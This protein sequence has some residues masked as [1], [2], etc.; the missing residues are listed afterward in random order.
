MANGEISVKP[1]RR[2]TLLA[3]RVFTENDLLMEGLAC[4]SQVASQDR[5]ARLQT[6]GSAGRFLAEFDAA[7]PVLVA[8]V[9]EFA[10]V[11]ALMRTLSLFRW[12]RLGG[13][14]GVKGEIPLPPSAKRGLTP[15]TLASSFGGDWIATLTAPADWSSDCKTFVARF[16]RAR[17]AARVSKSG[18]DRG[19]WIEDAVVAELK[20]L[21][22]LQRSF[23]DKLQ[24]QCARR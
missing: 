16:E 21:G 5:C 23:A 7:A 14:T 17:E 4:D 18:Y 11:E 13:V 6:E 8:R 12:A 24:P 22:V 19:D 3:I 20:E 10:D 1:E 2:R 9:A 15:D